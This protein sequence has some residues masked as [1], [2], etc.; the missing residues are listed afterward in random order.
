M[1]Y[2][3]NGH[4]IRSENTAKSM[5]QASKYLNQWISRHEIV[6]DAL[7]FGCGKLRY[8]NALASRARKLT[9]V[10]S[11]VQLSRTQILDGRK[12]TVYDYIKYHFSNVRIITYEAF[13]S[14]CS[15]YD[16]VLCA[17]VLSAIPI[18]K[19]RS[20]AL[21]CIVQRL[22]SSGQCL[23]VTQFRN[24][25]FKKIAES[26]YAKPHLDGLLRITDHGSFYYGILP[27][28]RLE[29]LV[30]Q[31]GFSVYKSWVIEQHAYVLAQ[32]KRDQLAIDRAITKRAI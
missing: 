20:E 24:S 10:D 3:I 1:R 30:S 4:E 19:V 8:S 31:H 32:P 22:K 21:R 23:F 25:Y 29:K 2:N 12:T 15:M 9:L 5:L 17:N 28:N 26:P 13:L 27:K 11:D 18:A 16:I 6:N 7:D 14:D